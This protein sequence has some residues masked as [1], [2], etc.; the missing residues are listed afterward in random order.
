[1]VS[2][3]YGVRAYRVSSYEQSQMDGRIWMIMNGRS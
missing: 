1:M 3:L 2:S